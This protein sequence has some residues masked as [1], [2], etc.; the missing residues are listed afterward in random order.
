METWFSKRGYP[1]KIIENKMKKVNFDESR[2]KTKSTI[3][4]SFVFTYHGRLKTLGK[5]IHQNLNLL[6]MNDKVKDTFRPG[7]MVSFRAAQKT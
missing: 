4:A 5:T 3:G 7:L 1:D 2:S 6:Y